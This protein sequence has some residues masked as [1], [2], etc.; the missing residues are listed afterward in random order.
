MSRAL[1][2]YMANNGFHS[3]ECEDDCYFF[4]EDKEDATLFKLTWG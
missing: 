2:Q 4:F 3:T 1:L